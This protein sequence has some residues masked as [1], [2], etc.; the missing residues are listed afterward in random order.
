LALDV[1]ASEFFR[2]GQYHFKDKSLGTLKGEAVVDYYESLSR[3]YPL[4]SI[5]DGFAEDDWGSWSLATR[6][7]GKKLQW[8]GDDLFVTQ[9]S[10]LK[11]G[12]EENVANAILIKLNQVGTLSET[13]DTMKLAA[14]KGYRNVVSHRSGESEDATL[15]HLVVGTGA[16]QVKT[17]SLSRSDRTA[18]YN[19]LLRLSESLNLSFA[20]IF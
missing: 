4:V 13:L 15:A 11:R 3:D 18:K 6:R 17:G 7:L 1:A 2:D 14:E 8:V 12:I 10:R 9:V 16:G 20:K 5:E 19:E